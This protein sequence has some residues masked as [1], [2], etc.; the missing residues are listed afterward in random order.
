MD[1]IGQRLA[2]AYPRTNQ[3]IAPVVKSFEQWFIGE[4][5]R[6]LYKG[7]WGAVGFVLLIVCAN[8]ANLMVA[9]AMGRSREISIRLALGAGRWRIIRQFLAQ[10]LMV[11]TLAG[12]IGWS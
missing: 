11:S 3:G 5:A 9:H 1:T 2:N 8:V 7:M 12:A 10:I 6:L 4:D